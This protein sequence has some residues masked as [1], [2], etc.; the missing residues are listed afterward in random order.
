MKLETYFQIA[1]L[2]REQEE[3]RKFINNLQPILTAIAPTDSLDDLNNLAAL[4]DSAP[5]N[6]KSAQKP[7]SP[8]PL[9]KKSNHRKMSGSS[10]LPEKEVEKKVREVMEDMLGEQAS[11]ISE[12]SEKLVQMEGLIYDL[13]TGS[14]CG[15]S[16]CG[17]LGLYPE[18]GV[19]I[20]IIVS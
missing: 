11:A 13:R 10:L 12:V 1:E 17:F 14:Q 19:I 5:N 16:Q 8:G 3:V 2:N 18:C 4:M 6:Q 9:R 15:F 20:I 7:P